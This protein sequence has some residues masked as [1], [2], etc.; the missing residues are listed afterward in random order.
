MI[1][2]PRR[3]LVICGV[4]G[5]ALAAARIRRLDEECEIIMF[6]RGSHI[7][8]SNSALPFYLSGMLKEYEDL[9][10][11]KPEDLKDLELCYEPPLEQ[12]GMW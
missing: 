5:G 3:V 4:A 8:F 10:L 6:E 12:L 9:L 1:M 11:M 7:S 2:K